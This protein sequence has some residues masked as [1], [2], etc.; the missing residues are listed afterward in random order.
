MLDLSTE[1]KALCF[2][3]S[4][5]KPLYIFIY[6]WQSDSE[7]QNGGWWQYFTTIDKAIVMESM[8]LDEGVLEGNGFELGS[9]VVHSLKVQWKNNGLRY[10]NMIAVPVQ[11]IGNEYIAYFDG[12]IT[13]EE[14]SSDG[15][16]VTA[17]ISSLLNEKLDVDVLPTLKSRTGSRLPLMVYHALNDLQIDVRTDWADMFA[18]ADYT[19]F[20]NDNTLP[21]TLT[22]SEFLKQIGEFLGCH[23]DTQ[24]KRIINSLDD[25][26]NYQ[27]TGRLEIGFIRLANMDNIAQSNIKPLPSG[28]K[29]LEYIQTDGRQYINTGYVPNSETKVEIDFYNFATY[30]DVSDVENPTLYTTILFGSRDDLRTN[31][32]T[33]WTAVNELNEIKFDVGNEILENLPAKVT[34]RLKISASAN[35][36]IINGKTTTV[37]VQAF[38]GNYPLYLFTNNNGGTIDERCAFG[39]LY[40][41]KIYENGTLQRDMIPC[42]RVTDGVVGLYDLVDGGFFTNEGMGEFIA[43]NPIETYTLPYYINLYADK[44]NKVNFDQIRVLTETGDNRSGR[45]NYTFWWNNDIKTTYEIKNNIFFEALSTQYWWYC[46]RAVREVGSYLESQNLYYTDLQTVYPPFIEGG[47]Y[48]IVKGKN[49]SKLPSGYL[50]LD[51]IEIK[52]SAAYSNGINTT[53]IPDSNNIEINIEFALN[54]GESCIFEADAKDDNNNILML[55]A[56]GNKLSGY[57]GDFYSGKTF[58]IPY[59]PTN[60]KINF[61]LKCGNGNY[62]YSGEFNGT[63]TYYGDD[64]IYTKTETMWLGTTYG[65]NTDFELYHF[66]YSQDGVKLCD[67]YPCMRESDGAIG[68]YDVIQNTFRVV[69]GNPNPNYESADTVVPVLSTTARGIHSMRADILCKATNTNKN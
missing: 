43:P 68:V 47:D 33:V 15:Q 28:Y 57:I 41:F 27:P 44:T 3:D 60:Q 17:E 8:E 1:N 48:L 56:I 5:L 69:E 30:S 54:G 46:E 66:S 40:S 52:K 65:R 53:I 63:G 64:V 13:K 49:Q 58:E 16:I 32:F 25:M 45:R 51:S 18:N 11:K 2:E 62:E 42:V 26:V 39:K 37:G 29:R 31:A 10:K 14:I 12:K 24:E 7:H 34:G 36:I 67:M 55:Y 59:V 6:Y 21:Q 4:T 61:N 23:I 22:L 38:N 9:F 19:I 50:A 35:E 20:L